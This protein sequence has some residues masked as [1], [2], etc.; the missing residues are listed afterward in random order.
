MMTTNEFYKSNSDD[1]GHYIDFE[2]IDRALVDHTYSESLFDKNAV[3]CWIHGHFWFVSK[4]FDPKPLE[5]LTFPNE[6]DDF[7]GLFKSLEK[8]KL[9]SYEKQDYLARI[10]KT[11][12][13]NWE[14]VDQLHRKCLK[15]ML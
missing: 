1:I 2:L 10:G 3:K 13:K 15:G 8:T 14:T 11:V 9:E 12:K 4:F 7:Y 6:S 5:R